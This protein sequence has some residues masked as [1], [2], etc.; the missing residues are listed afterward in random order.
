MLK[1]STGKVMGKSR[2]LWLGLSLFLSISQTLYAGNTVGGAGDAGG[3][4]GIRSTPEQ[5]KSELVNIKEKVKVLVEANYWKQDEFKLNKNSALSNLIE[6]MSGKRRSDFFWFDEEEE[7]ILA[8]I[9][10]SKIVDTG[11]CTDARE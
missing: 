7:P 8:A 3:G 1:L 10:N 11:K 2:W 6:K 5:V 4:N 9:E